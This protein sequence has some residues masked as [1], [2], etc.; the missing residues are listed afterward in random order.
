MQWE[1]DLARARLQ[2]ERPHVLYARTQARL[3]KM[4]AEAE[5]VGELDVLVLLPSGRIGHLRTRAAALLPAQWRSSPHDIGWRT[6]TA[7]R[8]GD[9]VR[10]TTPDDWTVTGLIVDRA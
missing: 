9:W 4:Q 8:H 7:T 5:R 3:D 6:G 1:L 10:F 2:R